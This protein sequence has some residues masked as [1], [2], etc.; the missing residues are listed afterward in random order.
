MAISFRS[1]SSHIIGSRSRTMLHKRIQRHV[2]TLGTLEEK[3]LHQ[4][5]KTILEELSSKMSERSITLAAPGY[6]VATYNKL[7]GNF[8]LGCSE[9]EKN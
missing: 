2:M 9:L 6:A 8:L 5:L 1:G 3:S 7:C 4:V